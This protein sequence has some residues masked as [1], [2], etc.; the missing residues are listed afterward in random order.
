TE[1]RRGTLNFIRLSP[2]SYKGIFLGKLLGTP[3]LLY[4]G[5]ILMIPF[6]L[7][8]GLS[9][10]IPLDEMVLF[11]SLVIG[12]A[13]FFNSFALLFG[14]VTSWLG[15]FQAWLGSGAVFMGLTMMNARSLSSD[16]LDWMN[17]FSPTILLRYLINRTGDSYLTFPFSFQ[18][19]Q[20]LTWFSLPIGIAGLFIAV[21]AFIHYGVWTAWIWQGLRRCFHSPNAT[22]L[23]KA[24]SYGFT[25]CF[26]LFNLGFT[27]QRF[28]LIDNKN[29]DY[30]PA[31][32]YAI[33]LGWNLILFGLLIAAL[34]PQRQALQ[35]WARY[36]WQHQ[37]SWQNQVRDLALGE[38]SPALLAIVFNLGIVAALFTLTMLFYA[39]PAEYLSMTCGL[40]L[41]MSLIFLG[42]SLTQLALMM[43]HRKRMVWAAGI[44]GTI[45][46]LPLIVLG[47]V[48]AQPHSVPLPFLFSVLSFSAIEHA[49]MGAIAFAI[50]S[51]WTVSVIL[52]FQL[53]RHLRQ[54]GAS[55]LKTL[56]AG[57]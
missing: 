20:N 2:Q 46:I 38:N 49:S 10:K 36:R 45:V 15:S 56:T 14:S 24:Q 44:V 3:I 6:Q 50:L 48:S 12:S 30:A 41:N 17:I 33:A 34:S 22:V 23:S 29:P 16:G 26:T 11:D 42:A 5:I 55:E 51:Q 9:A 1:E 47:V 27:A 54:A 7:F 25:A 52:N 39:E 35:D 57:L 43:K 31:E 40:V 18:N 53:H 28:E 13:I 19:V 8:V 4:L 21:F 32:Y 37:R